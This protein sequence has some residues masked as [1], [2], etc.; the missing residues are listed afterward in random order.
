[1]LKTNRLII[2]L[3]VLSPLVLANKLVS[4]NIP[5]NLRRKKKNR[6]RIKDYSSFQSNAIGIIS[7]SKIF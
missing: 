5:F 2:A 7:T 3:L 1:M 4:L 6:F